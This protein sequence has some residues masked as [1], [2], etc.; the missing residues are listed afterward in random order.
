MEFVSG[1][2]N[3]LIGSLCYNYICQGGNVITSVCPGVCWSMNRTM[4]KVLKQLS[5]NL[6]VDYFM[7][8][9]CYIFWM[10][11]LKWELSIITQ[12]GFL[13]GQH[14]SRLNLALVSLDLV[15]SVCGS[16]LCGFL[17]CNFVAVWFGLKPQFC[18]NK[19]IGYNLSSGML[20]STTLCL[21]KVPTFELSVNLSNLNRFSKYLHWNLKCATKLIWHYPPHLRHVAIL[22]WEIKISN[23]LQIF[24]RYGRNS[25]KLNV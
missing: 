6:V 5:W 17:W 23:F 9:T 10:I 18:T 24:S 2:Y 14:N 3:W 12:I 13:V 7:G 25:K 11:L 8:I 16:F 1:V 21:K 22:P 15:L 4:Q 19:V 20:G